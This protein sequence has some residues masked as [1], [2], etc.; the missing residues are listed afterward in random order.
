MSHI[1]GY[2]DFPFEIAHTD[3]SPEAENQINASIIYA[4]FRHGER[5]WVIYDAKK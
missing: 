1:Y 3:C 2:P 5:I 4:K